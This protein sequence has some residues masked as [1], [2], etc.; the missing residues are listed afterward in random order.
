MKSY[1]TH[2]KREVKGGVVRV[3]RE[4]KSEKLGKKGI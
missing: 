2:D 4:K 3:K 1:P